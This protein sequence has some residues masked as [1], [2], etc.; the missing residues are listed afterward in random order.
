MAKDA[1]AKNIVIHAKIS[2]FFIKS[3]LI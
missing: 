1:L 3:P 2:I